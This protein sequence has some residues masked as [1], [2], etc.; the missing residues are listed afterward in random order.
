MLPFPE[1]RIRRGPVS[2]IVPAGFAL[3]ETG[4]EAPDPE[5]APG[6]PVACS[7]G[8][9]EGKGDASMRFSPVTL[10]K[11]AIFPGA[12]PISEDPSDMNSAAF[13]ESITLMPVAGGGDPLAY[14]AMTER[15]IGRH[16]E[17]HRMDLCE[18]TTV[19]DRP[20]ARSQSS[21]L[22]NFRIFRLVIAWRSPAGLITAT[23]TLAEERLGGGWATLR[24]LAESVKTT[25][26]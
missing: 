17:D 15:V 10:V 20:A 23:L 24:R 6:D 2:F 8:T 12:P 9:V 21:F 1:E 25:R 18:K 11:T 3:A 5:G 19:G 13:P 26:S 4:P 22:S 16:F 7:C 14:L